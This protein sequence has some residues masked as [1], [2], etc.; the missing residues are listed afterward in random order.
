MISVVFGVIHPRL[1]EDL[2]KDKYEFFD[3]GET[4]S[5]AIILK[6]LMG[7]LLDYNS[8]PNINIVF[9]D[10]CKN[11]TL[12]NENNQ[13][14]VKLK[15]IFQEFSKWYNGVKTSSTKMYLVKREGNKVVDVYQRW[16]TY[17]ETPYSIPKKRKS[18]KT[19]DV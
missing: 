10:F 9:N 4:E 1:C 13:H 18:K 11:R 12:S 5:S 3:I 15:S 2:P 8:H 17:R 6:N 19:F 16:N 14:F 7:V